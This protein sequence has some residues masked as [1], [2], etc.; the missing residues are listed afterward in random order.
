MKN[1]ST[2]VD[3]GGIGENDAHFFGELKESIGW[4]SG[5]GQKK[6]RVR[7]DQVGILIIDMRTGNDGI[8]IMLFELFLKLFL[9]FI[10]LG[11]YF[12]V[13]EGSIPDDL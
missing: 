12:R 5:G 6:L 4:I 9:L 7:V 2:P 3:P 13:V 1:G 11:G 10:E 8:V